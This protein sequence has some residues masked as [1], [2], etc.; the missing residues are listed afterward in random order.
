MWSSKDD[1]TTTQE[2]PK[3]CGPHTA[4][5]GTLSTFHMPGHPGYTNELNVQFRLTQT[6]Y[7]KAICVKE[8]LMDAERLTLGD[9][10][11][12][13]QIVSSPDLVQEVAATSGILQTQI[14]VVHPTVTPVT[15]LGPLFPLYIL[16]AL[17]H[18]LPPSTPSQCL[19]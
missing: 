4:G 10:S 9:V 11:D 19:P 17:I 14:Q 13:P 2:M 16:H 3:P 15:S 8:T 5:Y 18:Q 1:T 6:A 12:I 7:R